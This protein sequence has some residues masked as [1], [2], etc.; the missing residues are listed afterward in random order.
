MGYVGRGKYAIMKSP[1][2]YINHSCEP[3]AYFKHIN[4]FR[5]NVVAIRPIKKEEEIVCD[6][7]IDSADDWRMKCQCGSKECRKVVSGL[8]SKLPK[9]MQKKY[10][11]YAP[12]WNRP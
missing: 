11:P 7:T 8:F 4:S 5:E 9:N 2:K 1:E 3:N 6:Y 12:E 10:L